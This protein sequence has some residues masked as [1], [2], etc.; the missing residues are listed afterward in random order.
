MQ[1]GLTDSGDKFI[2]VFDSEEKLRT[3]EITEL[4]S[5]PALYQ[6]F[7]KPLLTGL[8]SKFGLWAIAGIMSYPTAGSMNEKLPEIKTRSVKEIV[9]VWKGH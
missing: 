2:I 5:H 8:L 9:G 6:Y 7:P 1:I 3:G 4:P